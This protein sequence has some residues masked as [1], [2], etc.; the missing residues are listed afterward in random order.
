ME[1]NNKNINIYQIGCG[2]NG[3]Y[4]VSKIARMIATKY[5]NISY[6][7]VD[8][9][10][11]EEKN[12]N[13]QNFISNDLG[14][15]KA[16]VLSQRYSTVFDIEIKYI[17]EF[18]N[19]NNINQI[20]PKKNINTVTQN[21]YIII[22]CVDNN[23]SRLIINNYLKQN[24]KEDEYIWIDVGNELNFGQIFINYNKYNMFD[25]IPNINTNDKHPDEL[26]C[27][28]HLVSGEQSLNINIMASLLTFNTLEL[29]FMDKL[30]YF[31][32]DFNIFNNI[33]QYRNEDY[34][35][36]KNIYHGEK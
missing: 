35:K 36:F 13:R 9:D 8:K 31:L 24:F 20:I 15:Y 7:L 3:S 22:G 10:K 1:L 2:G 12:L 27:A 11:V 4:L 28:E 6:T 5:K 25:F 34:E 18:I 21:F 16:E 23:K 33:K 19:I 30:Y 17:N 14:L 32:I 29:I 26:S